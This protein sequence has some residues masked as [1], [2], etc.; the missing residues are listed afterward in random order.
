[1]LEE[2]DDQNQEQDA[3]RDDHVVEIVGADQQSG[4]R[5][6]DVEEGEAV[7]E[8]DERVDFVVLRR[9][10][11]QQEH[12]VGVDHCQ[13]TSEDDGAE[14]LVAWQG[15]PDHGHCAAHL[16]Q[17]ES[18]GHNEGDG[19][20]DLN[21][22]VLRDGG[23]HA[24]RVGGPVVLQQQQAC[25]GQAGRSQNAQQ[26]PGVD[27]QREVEPLQ[28][29]QERAVGRQQRQGGLGQAQEEHGE[30]EHR[31]EVAFQNAPADPPG[32]SL[33]QLLFIDHFYFLY[34]LEIVR[35]KI[36]FDHIFLNRAMKTFNSKKPS[37]PR[38][39]HPKGIIQRVSFSL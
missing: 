2:P 22:V 15:T 7:G 18:V 10:V 3:R 6:I 21:C 38:V 1:M 12:R 4:D 23:L 11:R 27:V 19:D 28:E 25:R 5:P 20:S 26:D 31:V 16:G 30:V 34:F 29:G 9:Q 35:L 32:Q 24:F 39:V 8:V 13:E 36:L 37:Y 33:S 17:A 14:S